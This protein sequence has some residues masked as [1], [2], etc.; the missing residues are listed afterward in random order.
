MGRADIMSGITQEEDLKGL[1][2]LG[3]EAVPE[4]K[5][6]AFPNRAP[7]RFYLVSIETHE[8]TCLCPVTSQPD[9]ARVRIDYV[10]DEKIV[11]SKSLKLYFWSFRNERVFHE[12]GTNV[13]LDDLVAALDPHYIRVVGMFNIRGGIAITTTAEHVKTPAAREFALP[14]LPKPEILMPR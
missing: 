12:H 1:S 5:L 7:G 4:R 13:F 3:R 10:P 2:K 8:F 11:E 9:F 14:L 6:E